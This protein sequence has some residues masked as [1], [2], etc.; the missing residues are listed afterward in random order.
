ML[1]LWLPKTREPQ[2][3]SCLCVGQTL[4]PLLVL[5]CKQVKRVSLHCVFVEDTPS[6]GQGGELHKARCDVPGR[7]LGWNDCVRKVVSPWGWERRVYGHVL[8]QFQLC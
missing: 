2:A 5:G 4:Q 7:G 6:V 1:S 8:P 3:L